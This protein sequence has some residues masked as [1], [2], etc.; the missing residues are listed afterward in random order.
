MIGHVMVDLYAIVQWICLLV[1]LLEQVYKKTMKKIHKAIFISS[2]GSVGKVLES[3][4]ADSGTTCSTGPTTGLAFADRN[5][6]R[7]ISP[8]L[9]RFHCTA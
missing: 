4:R 7:K 8:D 2:V 5:G 3:L 1:V 6:K 9:K